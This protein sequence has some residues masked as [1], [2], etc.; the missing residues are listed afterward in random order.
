MALPVMSCAVEKRYGLYVAQ[1]INLRERIE[2][3]LYTKITLRFWFD[4]G[5]MGGNGG[6]S[7]KKMLFSRVRGY[8]AVTA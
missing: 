7:L 1:I 8:R 4:D 2:N 5:G 3:S 6:H